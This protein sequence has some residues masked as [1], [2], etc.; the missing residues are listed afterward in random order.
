[1]RF[2]KKI[3]SKNRKKNKSYIKRT[4]LS[5][6]TKKIASILD[7]TMKNVQPARRIT[8]SF[9]KDIGI[10]LKKM[11]GGGQCGSTNMNY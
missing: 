2:T 8:K 3:I 5:N 10:S 11:L 9:L 1:M 7:S 6:T 4:R